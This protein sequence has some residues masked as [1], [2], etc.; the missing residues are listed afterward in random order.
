MQVKQKVTNELTTETPAKGFTAKRRSSHSWPDPCNSCSATNFSCNLH[1]CI[2][3]SLAANPK[4]T[5]IKWEIIKKRYTNCPVPLTWSWNQIYKPIQQSR[6]YSVRGE[7]ILLQSSESTFPS[8]H[9]TSHDLLM[10]F[11]ES[12]GHAVA[13]SDQ[14]L[15]PV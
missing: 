5:A 1:K 15:S 4:P 12:R 2:S 7:T 14:V 13:A 3:C 6:P 8:L 9:E 11:E 10:F